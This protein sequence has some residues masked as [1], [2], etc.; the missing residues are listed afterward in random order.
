MISGIRWVS[1][2][3]EIAGGGTCFPRCPRSQAEPAASV[4]DA[5]S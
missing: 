1:E 2:L 3:I 4:A 5:I